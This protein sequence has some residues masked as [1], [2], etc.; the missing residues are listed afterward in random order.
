MNSAIP[1]SDA[2]SAP[3]CRRSC[4]AFHQDTYANGNLGAFNS[5]VFTLHGALLSTGIL[6]LPPHAVTSSSLPRLP[7]LLLN[8]TKGPLLLLLLLLLHILASSS[9]T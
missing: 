9:S 5:A 7:I 3:T 2:V 6:L 1:R 4:R 8:D